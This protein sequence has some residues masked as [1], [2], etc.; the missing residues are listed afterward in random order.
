MRYPG[1]NNSQVGETV[2]YAYNQRMLPTGAAGEYT[3]LSSATYD[4]AGRLIQQILGTN[5]AQSQYTYNPWTSQGGRLMQITAGTPAAPVSLLNLYYSY[6]PAGN[7]LSIQDSIMGAPQIQSFEY[8]AMDRLLSA[9]ASGGSQGAGDYSQGYSYDTTTGNLASMD[10]VSYFYSDLAH[11]HAVTSLSSGESFAYN[12]NGGMAR[13]PALPFSYVLL[14]LVVMGEASEESE[15]QMAPPGE[16]ESSSP[17]PEPEEQ[18]RLGGVELAHSAPGVAD[19]AGSAKGTT[20]TEATTWL[21]PRLGLSAAVVFQLASAGE[22]HEPGLP[23]ARRR[24]YAHPEPHTH[25]RSY[26]HP[27]S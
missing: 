25:P 27:A 4:A 9:S 18:S 11:P 6:D 14:P 15:A 10:G 20:E 2:T 5:Q 16:V 7:I 3:Y 12:A 23:A 17:Y 1:G 8:D 26:A 24:P 22:E 19:G 21:R 13:K